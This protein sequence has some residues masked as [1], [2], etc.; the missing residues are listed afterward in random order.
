MKKLTFAAAA[1]AVALASTSLPSLAGGT[2]L[3]TIH[4]AAT[5][6]NT[7]NYAAWAAACAPSA[8]VTDDFP[9]YTWTGPGACNGWY[10]GWSKFTKA[11]AINNVTVLFGAPM[12][13]TVSGNVA[14]VVLP[15]TLHFNQ[16]G[17][18]VRMM[19]NVMT[20]V[21]RKGMAGDWKMT[22]WTW[23]DGK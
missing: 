5:D 1:F 11:H 2:P 17:K 21:L 12:H 16:N 8:M 15:A 3:A 14:Y 4:Q 20:I 9:P 19:S 22:A 13:M 10:N 18:P 6:F 23:A 7:G